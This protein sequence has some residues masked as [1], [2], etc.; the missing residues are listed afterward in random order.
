M[1]A[2]VHTRART[3]YP[4][5]F[6]VSFF[7]WLNYATSSATAFAVGFTNDSSVAFSG[8]AGRAGE[9]A[10]EAHIGP[11]ATGGSGLTSRDIV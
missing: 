10:F 1:A 6:A 8:P 11:A 3:A 4:L 9:A 2:T 7:I 5:H